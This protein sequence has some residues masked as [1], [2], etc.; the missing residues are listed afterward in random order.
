MTTVATVPELR[1]TETV[2]LNDSAMIPSFGHRADGRPMVGKS[3]QKTQ[4]PV[5]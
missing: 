2:P 3:Y 4:G 5:A 1:A